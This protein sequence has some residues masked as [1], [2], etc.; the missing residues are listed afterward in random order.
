MR[1]KILTL[2]AALAILLPLRAEAQVQLTLT[3]VQTILSQSV[4]R[5]LEVSPNALIAIVDNNGIVLAIWS[6]SGTT[7]NVVAVGAAVREAGTA[8]F[9]SSD[10]SALS[11]RTAQ[12][13]VQQH[14]P[15]GIGNRPPGPLVGV[16]FS[17]LW[18]TL[19][20]VTAMISDVNRFK[21]KDA[22]SPYNGSVP[23]AL[24]FGVPN[25]RL[26]ARCSSASLYKFD[27]TL[28][29]VVMVG[30]IGVY[31][32]PLVSVNQEVADAFNVELKNQIAGGN[33][34]ESV[35]V[36]GAIGFQPPSGITADNITNDGIRLPYVLAKPKQASNLIPFASLPG[37][38]VVIPAGFPI[39]PG[40][41][42]SG[43]PVFD[44]TPMAAP[45]QPVLPQETFNG[46]TG[47]YYYPIIA[48]PNPGLINGVPRLSAAEVHNIVMNGA[49]RAS[50]T[51][52]AIRFPVGVPMQCWVTVVGNPNVNG[53]PPPVLAA[54]RTPNAPMFSFDVAVQKGR[55]A[56]FFSSPQVAQS[57]RTVGFLAQD[58][59]PPGIQGNPPTIYGPEQSLNGNISF[60]GLQI[61][62]SFPTNT[63]PPFLGGFA[64][65][66]NL[67]NG[68]TVFP[69]GFPLYRIRGD[70]VPVLIGAV[71]ISG[72]GV[73]Q[74]DIVGI[75]ATVG[76]QAPLGIRADAFTVGGARLPYA[77]IPRNP[78]IGAQ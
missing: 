33:H 21:G 61:Q 42:A 68:I 71:G 53:A 2:A 6:V 26:G 45:P 14:V 57:S 4:S 39:N 62:F 8:A 65:N 24:G 49:L 73:D 69:G 67:P 41:P 20:G 37:S 43:L 12:F 35:A 27:A 38:A 51:R 48:D 77:K 70:G 76:Y 60:N 54:F 16:E 7:P 64:P 18:L 75:S 44:Y 58:H 9:L 23:G 74:D 29:H 3:D 13:I 1:T 66:G 78:D 52:G 56:L 36:T 10:Q 32:V 5:A 47:S 28:G 63:A 30:G 34:E 46:Q 72:D 59:Y 19:D 40:G 15:P 25:T 11:S 50:T 55:T 31:P 17:Q 22:F